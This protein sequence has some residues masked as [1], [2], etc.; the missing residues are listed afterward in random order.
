M[1][2]IINKIS[3]NKYKIIKKNSTKHCLINGNS[4]LILKN[5]PDKSVDLIFT[6]PPYNAKL[7]YG[8]YYDDNLSWEKYYKQVKDWMGDYARILKD[9]GSFYLMNY[10]EICARI[11]PYI[12]GE[13]KLKLRRWITWH[14]PTNI[15][16]SKKNFTRS[17]RAILFFT[18]SD[19]YTFN[20][21]NIL[22]QYK[23]PDVGKIKKLLK[24]GSRGRTAYDVLSFLD[25][26]DMNIT[27][28]NKKLID[29]HDVNLLKNISKDRLNKDHPC[30]LPFDLIRRFIKVSSN[31]GDTVL[32]PFAGTFSTNAVAAELKRNSIGIELNPEYVKLGIKRLK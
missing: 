17:Q 11:L 5:L 26:L 12:E 7:D 30:Q 29:V 19:D 10:P 28:G 8:G 2:K 14:Y 15:G 21:E 1:E 4:S 32:D 13:L 22:Q 6:D 27:E 24:G 23:N 18:K 9:T 31:E 16:H 20:R 25:L 3:K